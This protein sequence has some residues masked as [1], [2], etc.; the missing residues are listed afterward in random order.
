MYMYV[1]MFD[2]CTAYQEVQIGSSNPSSC[3]RIVKIKLTDE[4]IAQIKPRKV[5]N[6]GKTEFFES[7]NVLCLQKD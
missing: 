5:D 4:Q 2:G 3:R 6:A 1:E 7:V